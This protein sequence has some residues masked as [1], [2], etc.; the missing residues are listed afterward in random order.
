MRPA[1]AGRRCCM[2]GNQRLFGKCV[3]VALLA[4]LLAAPVLPQSGNGSVRGTVSDP[5]DAVVPGTKV[6]LTNTANN[7]VLE[8]T[9]NGAGC[10]VYPVVVPGHYALTAE[11]PAL[12]K[13]QA[14]LTVQTAQSATLELKLKVATETTLVTVQDATPLVTV[15][16]TSLGNVLERRRIEQ[17]PINGRNIANLLL[18]IPGMEES[19]RA[20]GMRAAP[21]TFSLMAPPSP[22]LSM[23]AAPSPGRRA[24]TRSKSSRWRTTA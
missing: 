11:A 2:Q 21:T 3:S 1:P 13:F 24:S 20:Y 23:A 12:S 5:T 19:S 22:T 18:L 7:V 9:T 8:T 4:A 10:Y 14:E 16:T 6:R 15:D 17:L